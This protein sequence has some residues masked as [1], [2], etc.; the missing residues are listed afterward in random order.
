MRAVVFEGA[1][2]VRVADVPEPKVE[3]AG[4][5][6]VR[7]SRVAICGSDLHFLHGKAPVDPGDVLGHEAMGVVEAVGEGVRRFRPGDRVAIAFQLA[8]G[9]C[10]FC[11]RWQTALCE[12]SRTLGAGAFGGGLPGAQ[13][14]L[15]RVPTADVNLL[16]LPDGL[17]DDRGVFVGDALTTAYSISSIG[18]IQAGDTVAVVGAGPIG[19]FCVQSALALGAGRV[20]ALDRIAGRLELAAS[21][22]AEPID[23]TR[24]HPVT[25]VAEASEGRGADVVLEAVGN[26]DA[27]TTAIE[28]VRRGGR[29]VLVGVYADEVVDVQ[30]GV[31]WAR[32]LT[33]RFAGLTPIH[34]L[35]EHVLAELQAGRLDPLPIV[36]HRLPLE[37]AARGYALFDRREATQV[38]LTP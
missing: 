6:V 10:W 16:A 17:D 15:V 33:L 12:E 11:R 30:L 22:G 38:L 26:A 5:A 37:E 1:G 14:E 7:V 18:D 21:A 27:F 24:R 9:A 35:W 32:G 25:A 2:V 19:F 8:C 3:E 28:A 36:S 4:D 13:A 20:M 31:Y 29:V 23:V 34:S